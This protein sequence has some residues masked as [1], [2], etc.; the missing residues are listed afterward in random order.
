MKS[1]SSL[2]MERRLEQERQTQ[3]R[4][5]LKYIELEKERNLKTAEWARRKYS[6]MVE[7]RTQNLQMKS[8]I[9]EVLRYSS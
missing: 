2:R 3:I 1:I 9:E 8:M 4:N 5:R 6:L 7:R